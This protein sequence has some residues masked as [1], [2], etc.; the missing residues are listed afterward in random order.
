M[1]MVEAKSV[2]QKIAFSP[3]TF[4]AVRAMNNLGILKILD[5]AG[6]DGIKSSEIENS[7][8]LSHYAV[9]TLLEAAES[10]GIISEKDGKYFTSKIVQCFLYDTMTQ[11]NADFVHD[12]C[13]QGAFYLQESFMSGKPEGLKVF[14]AWPTVY[15]GLSQ[16]PKQ[17]LKSWFAFDHF[18]SDNAFSDVI[19]IILEK[20]PKRVFDAGCNTGKFELAMFSKGFKGQMTL[21][22]LPQQ[23]K[24]AEENLK[25]AG[26]AQNCIFYPIDMLKQE[27]KFPENPD[28][29]L[30]SQFLDCFSKE[31]I[32][33][34]VQKAFESMN[35]KSILYILEPFWDNQKFEAAK[36]SLTHTSLYFTAIA[37]GN[38]KMYSRA[39]MEQCVKSAGLK[40]KKLH[41]NIGTHEYTLLE[42]GKG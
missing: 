31:Q 40:V 11:I 28:A 2:A 6:K 1:K 9:S 33:S 24:K 30:M 13:Y 25:A 36:L 18:Y 37:N 27:T 5:D 21:L 3:L 23:L 7:L 42:C 29:I 39:E 16:L 35:E 38:S 8:N 34:I 19:K 4:Q 32:I 14:G 41:E 22:D 12:V 17:V 15:E 10:A 20:N 26:Y